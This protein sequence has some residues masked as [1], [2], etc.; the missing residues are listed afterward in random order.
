MRRLTHSRV[1]TGGLARG[2]K[3]D[4]VKVPPQKIH[5]MLAQSGLGSRR[6]MEVL[7]EQGRITVNSE[8]AH[9]GA[10]VGPRDQVRVDGRLVRLRF[11]RPLARVLLYHKPEG[12]IVSRGDP[13]GRPSV[14]DKLPLLRGARW[15]SVGRLDYNTCGLLIFTTSGELANC[16]MHPRFEVER[17]Y[18]IRIRGTL[19]K[20]QI[21]RLRG[22]VPLADGEARVERI[23]EQG[24][25][26]SNRWYRVVVKKGRNRIVRRL[27]EALELP[28]SRLMRVRFGIV[29]LPTWLKR[30]MWSEMEPEDARKLSEWIGV[31]ARGEAKSGFPSER[32]KPSGPLKSKFRNK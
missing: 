1:A 2:K 11:N 10:R 16:L 15:I 29:S 24:G 28:V 4:L 3:A 19:L 32:R 23:E 18:A 13:E 27:F 30:G 21:D 9:L 22:G 7:I 20:D 8:R 12:E 26:G 14:F 5:K 17:E 31:S 25:E 6:A